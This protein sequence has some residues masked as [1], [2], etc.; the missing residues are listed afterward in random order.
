MPQFDWASIFVSFCCCVLWAEWG[1][2]KEAYFRVESEVLATIW[3]QGQGEVS[4]VWRAGRWVTVTQPLRSDRHFVLFHL[5]GPAAGRTASTHDLP[6]S[7]PLRMCC[8]C[9][10]L[11]C[12]LIIIS[13]LFLS[14][15][16]LISFLK[17]TLF[18][19]FASLLIIQSDIS[20]CLNKLKDI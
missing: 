2:G 13:L 18:S 6:P 1:L 5:H 3:G 10:E 12:N 19:S 15:I 14:L 11:Q 17:S 7:T 4:A 9:F 8:Q 20:Q 16:F